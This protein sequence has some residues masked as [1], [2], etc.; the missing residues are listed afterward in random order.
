M[1]TWPDL[2]SFGRE[3]AGLAGDLD[4]REQRQITRAQGLE[5]QRIADRS[6]AASLGSDRAF[7][8]WLRGAP[9]A[10]DT[11]LRTVNGSDTLM[12]PTRSSAGPWTVAE[13][14]RNQGNASGFAGPG[15][16]R[17]T[18][19]TARTKAGNVRK[20][21]GRRSRRWNGTTAGKGTA[22]RAQA[23]MDAR[24]PKI[25]DKAVLK[26]TRKRFDVT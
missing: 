18:G 5:A 8:G 13:Q 10:L 2:A 25:A 19:L 6:A 21:R 7:G 1:P 20:V 23:E 16:N 22:S 14:G 9:I 24:L 26:V 11:R 15:I 4:E 12:T 17:T 3:L